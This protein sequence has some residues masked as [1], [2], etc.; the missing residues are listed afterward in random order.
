MCAYSSEASELNRQIAT[1]RCAFVRL[2][3]FV[4]VAF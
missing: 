1:V 4:L 3:E 2:M